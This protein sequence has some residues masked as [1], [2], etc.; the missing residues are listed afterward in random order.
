MFFFSKFLT[1]C[2]TTFRWATIQFKKASHTVRFFEHATNYFMIFKMC[3]ILKL[4]MLKRYVIKFSSSTTFNCIK[5]PNGSPL[6]IDVRYCTSKFLYAIRLQHLRVV[7]NLDAASIVFAYKQIHVLSFFMNHYCT[8]Q[9]T[10]CVLPEVSRKWKLNAKHSTANS[11]SICC[12]LQVWNYFYK[13]NQSTDLLSNIHFSPCLHIIFRFSITRDFRYWICW[14]KVSTIVSE[15][16]IPHV[17]LTI[18]FS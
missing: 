15:S 10:F 5:T 1:K 2:T 12:H 9:K 13:R 6:R 3:C 11:T 14:E 7:Q 4:T 8:K 18:S 16:W 17:S